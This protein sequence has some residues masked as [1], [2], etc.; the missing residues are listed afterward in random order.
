MFY[1]IF[2]QIATTTGVM[3]AVFSFPLPKLY[4]ISMMWTL[5][6][7]STLRAHRHPGMSGSRSHE[8]SGGRT[9]AHTGEVELSRIQVVTQ[10]QVHQDIDVSRRAASFPR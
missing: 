1:L 6:A 8:N 10:T 5:N 9:R 2:S 4:A 3:I 7:R